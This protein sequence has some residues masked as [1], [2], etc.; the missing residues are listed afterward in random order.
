MADTFTISGRK[1]QDNDGDGNLAEDL[2][3]LGG[4]TIFIDDD[5]DG[6]FDPGERRTLTASDSTGFWSIAGLTLDD[7]GKRVYEVAQSGWTQTV[8][9]AGYV[10]VDPGPSGEQTGLDFGNFENFSIAG[11]KVWDIDGD[12]DIARKRPSSAAGPSS[13]TTMTTVCS[14][15]ASGLR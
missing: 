2:T 7:V 13:S 8:G 4:W 15:P 14:T 5:G 12:G 6:V 9:A 3:F 10:I 1:V 11:R